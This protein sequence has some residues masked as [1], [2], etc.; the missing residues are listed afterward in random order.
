LRPKRAGN[1]IDLETI[2][3]LEVS[4]RKIFSPTINPIREGLG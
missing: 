1:P 3:Y 2:G 4:K